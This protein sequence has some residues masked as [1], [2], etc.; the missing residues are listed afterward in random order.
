MPK[1]L[2]PNDFYGELKNALLQKE[3]TVSH[4]KNDIVNS[5]GF[6]YKKRGA[7]FIEHKQATSFDVD[8]FKSVDYNPF[9]WA[10]CD[11]EIK[12]KVQIQTT[13]APFM[14]MMQGLCG[15]CLV[16]STIINTEGA[17]TTTLKF[18]CMA[19]VEVKD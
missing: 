14:C 15:K 7:P 9:D 11:G 3:C 13:K 17:P 4:I 5:V 16:V 2:S 12:S 19:G 8:E 1:S 6:E 18:G 10:Y